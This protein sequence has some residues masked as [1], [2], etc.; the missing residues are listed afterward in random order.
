MMSRVSCRLSA[1][2]IRLL[3]H[4]GPPG[5]WASLT[6]GLPGR[7]PDLDGVVTFRT[8]ETRP[9]RVLSVPRGDGVPTTGS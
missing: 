3:D 5:S 7:R 9:G 8:A 6:V 4:P 1:T 2:G